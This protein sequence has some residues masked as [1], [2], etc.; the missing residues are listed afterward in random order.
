MTSM[1][2]VKMLILALGLVSLATAFSFAAV[3]FNTTSTVNMMNV[4]AQTGL[5]GSVLYTPMAPGTVNAG[6]IIS[7]NLPGNVPISYLPEIMVSLTGTTTSAFAESFGI[8]ISGNAPNGRP[9]VRV[10]TANYSNYGDTLT[11]TTTGTTIS[12]VS[13]QVN[14][15]SLI[16]SF[17]SSVTFAAGDFIKFD[18]VRVDANQM[19]VG[20]GNMQVTLTNVIGQATTDTPQLTVATFVPE[21]QILAIT[22]VTGAVGTS[23]G[24]TFKANGSANSTNSNLV[25]VTIK[26]LFPNA[27]E[28]KNLTGTFG[29]TYYTR[30][31]LSLTIP[32]PLTITGVT[33]AGPDGA[34]FTNGQWLN[35]SFQVPAITTNPLEIAIVNQN[36]NKLET[37]QVGIQFGMTAG[38]VMP[39]TASPITMTAML[40]SPTA[41]P[42]PY[43]LNASFTNYYNLNYRYR[44]AATP[45]TGPSIPVTIVPLT[46]NLL[47]AYS[48]AMRPPTGSNTFLYDTGIAITNLSGSNPS[49]LTSFPVGTP[50]TITVTL[51]PMRDKNDT[52][53]PPSYSFNTSQLTSADSKL[54]LDPTTG[55]LASKGTWRVLLSQLLKEAASQYPAT[56]D[57]NGF[58]RF[59]CNFQEAAGVTYMGD[60]TFMNA[61]VG[62]QMASD[63]PTNFSGLNFNVTTGA[64][65]G[66]VTDPKF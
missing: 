8:A 46:S 43:S 20:G 15:Y 39:I 38:G 40:D 14:Q 59:T 13:V 47:T 19:A 65:T 28:T 56:K 48:S 66:T 37:L 1:K 62:F 25:T 41:A 10:G 50:G 61:A 22:G 51:Y 23:G 11:A 60:G 6:E 53:D 58:I 55:A 26:E 3:P 52:T 2:F 24:I 7:L 54:G 4:N 5:I 9:W 31:K 27:F 49:T 57:F 45:A 12:G 17:G 36:P 16:L 21:N 30:I 18:G 34:T 29:V 33:L 44:A 35:A 42:L 63:I 64:V 32:T